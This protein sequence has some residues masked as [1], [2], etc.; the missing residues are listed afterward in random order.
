MV[1]S[2]VSVLLVVVWAALSGCGAVQHHKRYDVTQV[3]VWQ[4]DDEAKQAS[5]TDVSIK[6]GAMN[7]DNGQY[8]MELQQE[9]QIQK[10]LY[11]Q[12]VSYVRI[13][14]EPQLFVMLN[15]LLWIVCLDSSELCLGDKGEWTGPYDIGEKTA[16]RVIAQESRTGYLSHASA[17]LDVEVIAGNGNQKWSETLRPTIAGGKA[18]FNLKDTL[19]KSPFKPEEVFIRAKLNAGDA[20]SA[21]YALYKSRSVERLNLVSENW[22]SKPERYVRYLHQIRDCM[23]DSDYQCAVTHFFKVQGLEIP[24]PDTFYFHFAKALSL[25]GD[26]ENA[27]EAARLYLKDARHTAYASEARAFL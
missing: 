11:D 16:V 26:T 12:P 10:V 3:E 15:P 8:M 5:V 13:S 23:S 19:Q 22:L 9:Y 6:S 24:L 1:R 20:S 4:S 7:M 17:V 27:R 18:S 14:K 2:V 25:A 21:H